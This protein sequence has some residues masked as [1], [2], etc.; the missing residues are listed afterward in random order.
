MDRRQSRRYPFHFKASVHTVAARPLPETF[1]TWTR[2]VSSKGI[3]MDFDDP[4]E[5]GTRLNLTLDLPA[6]IIGKPVVL[7]C[8]ARIVRTVREGNQVGVG[9]LIERY[10]FV[11]AERMQTP[12]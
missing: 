2:D 10:E 5:P 1:Q 6:E 4:P 7:R 9:A 3:C 12:A 11:P 8:I